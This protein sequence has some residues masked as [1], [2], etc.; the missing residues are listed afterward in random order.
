ME[1]KFEQLQAIAPQCDDV[2]QWAV[3][4]NTY[5][6]EYGIDTPQE[7]AR[8]LAQT[9]HES[10]DFSVRSENLNYSKSGLLKIFRKYFDEE[11]ASRYARNPRMIANRVYANRMGNGNEASGDG[12]KFRGRGCIQVTGKTN[13]HQCSIDLLGNESLLSTPEIVAEPDMALRSALWFWKK[14][15]L[16]S[17]TDMIILTKRINGGTHGLADRQSRYTHALKVLGG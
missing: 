7:I 2:I 14:N 11:S 3:L 16:N 12:W 17:V 4:L 15:S 5:L 10:V 9:T 8:F 1:I 13:Y 6:P